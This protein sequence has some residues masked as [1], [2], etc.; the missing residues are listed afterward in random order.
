MYLLSDTDDK[1]QPDKRPLQD[2]TGRREP[3][4]LKIRKLHNIYKN[5]NVDFTSLRYTSIIKLIRS[6]RSIK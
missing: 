1:V 6:I 4:I 2:Y 5:R 3:W